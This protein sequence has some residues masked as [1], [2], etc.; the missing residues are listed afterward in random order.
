MQ[1]LLACLQFQINNS[2]E[3]I[4]TFFLEQVLTCSNRKIS[5]SELFRTFY[6]SPATTNHKSFLNATQIFTKNYST[7]L[8]KYITANMVH[9]T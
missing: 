2:I 9:E 6:A 1:W 5:S 3:L 4:I 7:H 8:N